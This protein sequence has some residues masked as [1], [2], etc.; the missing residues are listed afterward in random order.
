MF[1]LV[2]FSILSI[3]IL[4]FVFRPSDKG[5]LGEKEMSRYL[6][7]LPISEYIVLNDIMLEN[8]FGNTCQ[9]DHVVLSIY[10]IFVIETKNYK[11]WIFGG[12]NSEE[13]TQNIYGKKFRLRNPI[14]QNYG[15]VKVL[16]KLLSDYGKYPFYSIV[17]FSVKC[18]LKVHVNDSCVVYYHQVLPE[19]KSHQQ[20]VMDFSMMENMACFI[21]QHDVSNRRGEMQKH[22]K[23]VRETTIKRELQIKNGICPRC[24]APLVERTGKFGRFRGCSNYPN[25][26]FTYES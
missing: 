6:K 25:C 1:G 21:R 23:N 9:I 24:G 2:L 4:C 26:K 17:A 18:K 14:K 15:H 11:G 8:E 16:Q 22:I 13:W 12:E 7:R 20:V 19:I 10:G 5:K 3:L